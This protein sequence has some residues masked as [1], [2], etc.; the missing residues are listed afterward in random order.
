MQAP[1]WVNSTKKKIRSQ[2]S[3]T[4]LCIFYI[5]LFV[6]FYV[7]LQ[8]VLQSYIKT[9][10]WPVPMAWGNTATFDTGALPP[11]CLCSRWNI[12]WLLKFLVGAVAP[13]NLCPSQWVLSCCLCDHLYIMYD[14]CLWHLEWVLHLP[15][16]LNICWMCSWCL[17]KMFWIFTC[18]NF[19][20]FLQMSNVPFQF[21]MSIPIKYIASVYLPLFTFS[22][23]Y[24]F[25]FEYV[26][27]PTCS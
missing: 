26:A 5:Y 15:V 18:F 25:Q 2:F 14:L 3:H 19:W 17:D 21:Y 23:Q 12:F 7:S 9:S 4:Y 1:V 6:N 27:I 22:S 20:L 13:L 24:V 8:T 10:L 11:F 16:Q